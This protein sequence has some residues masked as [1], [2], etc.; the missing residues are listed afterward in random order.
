M[1]IVKIIV[2]IVS[3]L[4]IDAD[5]YSSD[6]QNNA[7]DMQRYYGNPYDAESYIDVNKD[8]SLK[9]YISS[10]A[11]SHNPLLFQPCDG[12]MI[13]G[14]LHFT[15]KTAQTALHNYNNIIIING[16]VQAPQLNNKGNYIDKFGNEYIAVGSMNLPIEDESDVNSYYIFG[17]I[18]NN[19]TTST[20]QNKPML[21]YN[22]M[23]E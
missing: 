20:A 4:A 21:D 10:Q 13:N 2:I 17:K 9:N 3:I 18:I 11:A 7:I 14:T 22:N 15:N 8:L 16:T 1:K 5:F 12:S 6:L 19:N 23:N